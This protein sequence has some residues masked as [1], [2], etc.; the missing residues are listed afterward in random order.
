MH[1]IRETEVKEDDEVLQ[2]DLCEV[3]EHLICIKVCDR[4]TNNC[5][6]ALSQSFCK[7]L[8]FTCMKCRRKGNP[9]RRLLHVELMLENFQGTEKVV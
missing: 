2:S 3:W 1:H 4:A 8:V 9:A 7:S 5:Y 6:A